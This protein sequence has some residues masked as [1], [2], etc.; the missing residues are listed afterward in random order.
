MVYRVLAYL[1]GSKESEISC[2]KKDGV[3]YNARMK[4]EKGTAALETGH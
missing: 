2:L 3:A 1:N 4:V